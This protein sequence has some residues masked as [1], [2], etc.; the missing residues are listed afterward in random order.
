MDMILSNKSHKLGLNE[1]VVKELRSHMLL[2]RSTHKIKATQTFY[3]A[4]LKQTKD[5]EAK[6][7]GV[8]LVF[9]KKC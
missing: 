7:P 5:L 9:L 4:M 1:G 3:H 6:V 8:Q 2:L